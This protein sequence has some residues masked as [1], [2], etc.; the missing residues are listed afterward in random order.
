M[1]SHFVL[2]HGIGQ[3]S[4][5]IHPHE[6]WHR[7]VFLIN[8]YP[9]LLL[10]PDC[11]LALTGVPFPEVT[12]PFCRVPLKLL[13]RILECSSSLPVADLVRFKSDVIFIGPVGDR[14]LFRLADVTSTNPSRST[15]VDV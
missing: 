5:D 9:S 7:P 10:L 15:F 14:F 3:T 4:D 6:S 1:P 11:S 13:T 2:C 12:V 8:S